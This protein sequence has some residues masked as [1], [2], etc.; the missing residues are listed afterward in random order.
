M[1]QEQ[2]D[3]HLITGNIGTVPAMILRQMLRIQVMQTEGYPAVQQG[4][5]RKSGGVDRE[6][7]RGAAIV[8]QDKC[9]VQPDIIE[10]HRCIIVSM[11]TDRIDLSQSSKGLQI[12]QLII[13][14]D[15]CIG[16]GCKLRLSF[17][18]IAFD[19]KGWRRNISMY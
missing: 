16:I 19:V 2:T 6:I 7:P 18:E 12:P 1:Q 15:F 14:A 9:L 13:N 3:I 4:D 17:T 10:S 5:E 11:D 8:C